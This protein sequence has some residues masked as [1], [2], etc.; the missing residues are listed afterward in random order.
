MHTGRWIVEDAEPAAVRDM[1]GY[2]Y[3]GEVSP[4]GF[5]K[6]QRLRSRAD[7]YLDQRTLSDTQLLEQVHELIG[8]GELVQQPPAAQD[9]LGIEVEEFDI[10]DIEDFEDD[11]IEDFEQTVVPEEYSE[12]TRVAEV[13]A[14]AGRVLVESVVPITL[15]IGTHDDLSH[16]VKGGF[17]NCH[18]ESGAVFVVEATQGG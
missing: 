18:V 13:D 3:T 12:S 7:G 16:C 15:T 4:E 9:E 2:I 6:H 14:A 17:V 8:L 1:I 10:E 5:E 11:V